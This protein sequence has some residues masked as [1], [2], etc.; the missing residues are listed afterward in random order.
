[1]ADRVGQQ[2]G[3]Y[4]LTRLL[5]RGGFAEVYLGEHI[6]MGTQAAIKVLHTQLIPTD[7]QRFM[8]EARTLVSLEHPHIMRVLDCGIEDGTPYL[9]MD[10]APHGTLRQRHPKGTLVPLVYVLSYISELA[11]ALQYAHDRKLIHRD[12]KPEN[13]LVG[14]NNEVLLSDFGIAVISSASTSQHTKAVA[15]TVTYMAPELIMGRSSVASD[16]YAIGIVVYEWLCGDTPFHGSFAEVT[17]QHLHA[18][19]PPLRQNNPSIPPAVEEITM[20][21]LAKDPQERFPRVQDFA[22][23]LTNYQQMLP[24]SRFTQQDQSY[25]FVPSDPFTH[26]LPRPPLPPPGQTLTPATTPPGQ[27]AS[28]APNNTSSQ[29]S[30]QRNTSGNAFPPSPP[31]SSLV[32]PA[33]STAPAYQAS[34]PQTPPSLSS[35]FYSTVPQAQQPVYPPPQQP[36]VQPGP[37]QRPR[38]SLGIIVVVVPLVLLLIVGSGLILYSAVLQPN[39]IH[40]KA[41]ATPGA[42]T[43]T[44]QAQTQQATNANATAAAQASATAQALANAQATGTAQA[45]ANA[46]ATV[47]AQATAQAVAT[48]TALQGIYNQATSGT[49]TLNDPLT[50]STASDWSVYSNNGSTCAFTGGALHASATAQAGGAECFNLTSNFSNFAYQVK[51]TILKGNTAAGLI[52]RLDSSGTKAYFFGVGVDGTYEL[53]LLHSNSSDNGKV[54]S[55]GQSSAIATGLNQANLLTAIVRGST[56]YLYV[57]KQYLANTSDTTSSSGRIGV[58]EGSSG[59]DSDVAFND[60]QVW[61]L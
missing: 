18:P 29:P 27:E 40:S 52:F 22:T 3:N 57:N 12:I 31:P 1:M 58:F 43:Q 35:P 42:Q 41:T 21:A 17:A 51:M 16:Q 6:H 46:T 10:Y 26:T 32:K 50:G 61:N 15:G 7:L 55:R 4:R 24:F 19:P 34:T 33:Y 48:A 37:K 60:A 28:A 45:I 9:V 23:A 11:P 59:T 2:F 25:V 14:R 56:I 47:Q 54:L 13:M 39:S 44:Q 5:G 8:Q 49:P 36:P 30:L 53:S 20:K 38:F